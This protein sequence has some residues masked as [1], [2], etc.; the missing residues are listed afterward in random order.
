MR[1]SIF[2][3][4]DF[5]LQSLL[6]IGELN[7]WPSQSGQLSP[8]TP[9]S[10]SNFVSSASTSADLS[11]TRQ[12]NSTLNVS[13]LRSRARNTPRHLQHQYLDTILRSKF[14]PDRMTALNMAIRFRDEHA[15][16]DPIPNE[17]LDQL[18]GGPVEDKYYCYCC[19]KA[20]K[21]RTITPARDHVRKSLGNFPFKCPNA[22]W[23]VFWFF[24]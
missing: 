9:A 4:W 22:W 23:C 2:C 3:S 20:R 5:S 8:P 11:N 15:R 13:T 14:P 17:L 24:F 21:L 18:L 16:T 19:P 6:D 10:P 1:P 12:Q 7:A